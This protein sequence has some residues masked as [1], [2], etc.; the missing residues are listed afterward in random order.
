MVV[1]WVMLFFLENSRVMC[2]RIF[3]CLL[4][5]LVILIMKFVGLFV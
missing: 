3:R 1:S 5:M 2:D 4:L